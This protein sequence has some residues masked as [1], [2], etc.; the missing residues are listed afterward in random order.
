MAKFIELGIHPNYVKAI[1]DLKII[2]PTPVQEKVIPFLVQNK[3][4]IVVQAQTGT[5]KTA[6]FGLPILHHINPKSDK[7]QALVLSPTRELGQQIAKQFFKFTKYNSDKIFTEA[8]YGGEHISKQLSRLTRT[9]HI[10]V[11]TP[12]RLVDLLE[13]KVVDLS[14]VRTVVLDEADEMLHMGFK[15]DLETILDQCPEKRNTWLFSATIP[16]E[17]KAI[18]NNY[19]SSEA[20]NVSVSKEDVVNKNIEHQYLVVRELDK[21]DMLI[22]FLKSQGKA[23]GVIFCTTK[24]MATTLSK[25]LLAKNYNCDALQ[26]DM[27]QKERDKVMR[28]I[29][30]KSLQILVSTDVAARGI[31]IEGLSYV[32]HYDLPTHLDFYTHRSGRTAR[33]GNKGMAISFVTSAEVNKIKAIERDLGIR[34]NQIR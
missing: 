17:V 21:L 2:D 16:K 19:L 15:K 14:G 7:V 33:G 3:S 22:Q 9:T 30:N 6:A 23:R 29:K 26:G 8:V 34:I 13:R 28:G 32:V 20:L 27:Q 12:G 18:I 31:D 4:D 5:G 25:Q 10:L 24:K 1:N 11:A